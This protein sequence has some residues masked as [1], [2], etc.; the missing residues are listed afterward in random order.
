MELRLRSRLSTISTERLNL[1]WIA[2]L[3][4]IDDQFGPKFDQFGPMFIW[5]IQTTCTGS[6]PTPSC[7]SLPSLPRE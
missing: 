1:I 4:R 6:L 3:H 2:G 5:A 7:I